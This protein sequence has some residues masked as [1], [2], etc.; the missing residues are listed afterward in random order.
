M[1]PLRASLGTLARDSQLLLE[2]LPSRGAA[3]IRV[4]A[5]TR[6]RSAPSRS[7]DPQAVGYGVAVDHQ[8]HL[9]VAWGRSAL[10]PARAPRPAVAADPRSPFSTPLSKSRQRA[11]AGTHCP[12]RSRLRYG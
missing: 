7:T 5:E 12:R 2:T 9:L 10:K 6:R 8:H 4:A 1:A 3:R 11:P